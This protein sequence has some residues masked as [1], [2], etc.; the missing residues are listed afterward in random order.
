MSRIGKQQIVIPTGVEVKLEEGLLSVKGPLGTLER[1]FNPSIVIKI[2]DGVITLE[3]V[4]ID[5]ASRALWGTYGSHIQNMIEGV[6]KG[7]S[8]KLLIEGVGFKYNVVGTQVVMDLGLSHQ[9]KVNIPA[10]V[11]V[12]TEKN[13]MTITGI[14]KEAVGQF[15]AIIRSYKVTEPYKGK[16]IRYDN[17]VVLR[18]QGKKASA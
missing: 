11:K 2:A 9:V 14:D 6:T 4:K 17:E 16:G 1:K 18:K 10:S 13:V 12:V 5:V 7:Y 8:K 15:A 3:P